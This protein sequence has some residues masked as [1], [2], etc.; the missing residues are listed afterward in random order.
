M[1]EQIAHLQCYFTL[2]RDST[3]QAFYTSEKIASSTNPSWQSFDISRYEDEVDLSSKSFILRVWVGQ[4]DKFRLLITMEVYLSGLHFLA[5]KLQQSLVKH[6]PNT[7][8]FGMLDKYFIFIDK[9]HARVKTLAR[10]VVDFDLPS[11]LLPAVIKVEKPVVRNS[12]NTSSLTR[13]QTVLRA[14]KQMQAHAR[15]YRRQI[16]DRLLA[17]QENTQRLEEREQLHMRVGQLRQE[18]IQ[19]TSQLHTAQEKLQTAKEAAAARDNKLTRDEKEVE[20]SLRVLGED[21]KD[22]IVQREQLVRENALLNL[23]RRHMLTEL[24]TCI[25]PI[26]EKDG[27]F[28]INGVRLPHAE[29]FQG[30]DET[31]IAVGLGYACHLTLKISQ[32]LGLPLR[33]PM[34]NRG[35]RSVIFDQVHSKLQDKDRE[36]GNDRFPLYSKGRDK[37]HFNYGVFLLNKNISQ[38]RFQCGMPTLDLRQI[39]QNILT[40]LSKLGVKKDGEAEPFNAFETPGVAIATSMGS[41]LAS[42]AS[43]ISISSAVSATNGEISRLQETLGKE[44]LNSLRKSSNGAG[45]SMHKSDNDGGV[46][47]EGKSK[48]KVGKRNEAGELF[49]PAAEDDFFAGGNSFFEDFNNEKGADGDGGADVTAD[50]VPGAKSKSKAVDT[51]SQLSEI[52]ETASAGETLTPAARSFKLVNKQISSGEDHKSG[53]DC[54]NSSSASDGQNSG[55]AGNGQLQSGLR[56]DFDTDSDNS[57]DIY[58]N[59]RTDDSSSSGE[60]DGDGDRYLGFVGAGGANSGGRSSGARV[61]TISDD[62]SPY[63]T[64]VEQILMKEDGER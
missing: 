46:S 27:K 35:S 18:F 56:R 51:N 54:E 62:H 6:T 36:F 17:S 59:N 22:H 45:V 42:H 64:D 7:V 1:R 16:E 14:I 9:G 4:D 12:Y 34:E 40:M 19:R 3:A 32:I 30:Q 15:R 58:R 13:I 31:M 25:Y 37:F 52:L 55:L 10:K 44:R 49:A 57:P 26:T 2:H 38:M 61:R 33:H 41:N 28:F 8:I 29:E 21:K 53:L 48:V 60:E 39:L 11:S 24:V 47:G 43:G 20:S 63:M 5:E 50:N 23:R